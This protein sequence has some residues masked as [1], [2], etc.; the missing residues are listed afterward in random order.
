MD[1]R[2]KPVLYVGWLGRAYARD[3]IELNRLVALQRA[4]HAGLPGFVV[5]DDADSAWTQRGRYM[6][7]DDFLLRGPPP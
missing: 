6:A 3:V 7:F 1:E 2:R 5:G 4:A